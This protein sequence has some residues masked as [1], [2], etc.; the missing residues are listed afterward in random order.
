MA[1]VTSPALAA[2]EANTVM[3]ATATPEMRLN[4]FI[5]RSLF[6]KQQPRARWCGTAVRID[7]VPP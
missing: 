1:M 2:A 3:A 6:L 4:N 7:G 5:I